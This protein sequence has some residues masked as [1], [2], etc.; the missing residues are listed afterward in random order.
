MRPAEESKTLLFLSRFDTSPVDSDLIDSASVI[1]RT[2]N[3]SH[4]IDIN[5]AVLAASVQ[6]HGGILYTLNVKHYPMKTFPVEKAW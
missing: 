1:Y 5:D 4:G 2:Y 6:K 3:P